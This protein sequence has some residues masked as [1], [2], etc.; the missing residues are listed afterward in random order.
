MI[1]IILFDIDNTLI[2]HTKAEKKAIKWIYDEYFKQTISFKADRKIWLEM[3]QKN[4][5][6]F[7]QKELT[8]KQQQTQRIKDVWR[9]LNITIDEESAR[10]IFNQYLKKYETSWQAFA[11]V[12]ELL[13][14]LNVTVGILSNGNLTQQ[15][16]KLQTANLLRFFDQNNIFTSEEIGSSKPDQKLFSYVKETLKFKNNR[17]LYIGDKLEYDI[18]P[19]LKAGWNAIW[20][21]HYNMSKNTNYDKSNSI[22]EL[23]SFLVKKYGKSLFRDNK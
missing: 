12:E 13:N 19:A 2:D 20:I 4:W 8:F 17:I 14:K 15:I 3:T 11:G 22:E 10:K 5:K 6:L 9:S 23:E 21:D 16:K 7:E 18:E 1:K